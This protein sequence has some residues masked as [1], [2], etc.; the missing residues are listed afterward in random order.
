MAAISFPRDRSIRYGP[1]PASWGA[2]A[3]GAAL[4]LSGALL[5]YFAFPAQPRSVKGAAIFVLA[6]GALVLESALRRRGALRLT[7]SPD[8][9]EVLVERRRFGLIPVST[10]VG[11]GTAS[12]VEVE[13][14][15][16]WP[17]FTRNPRLPPRIG[18]R[19]VVIRS[20]GTR[21]AI[22]RGPRPGGEVHVEAAEA[23]REVLGCDAASAVTAPGRPPVP[24]TL[25]PPLPTPVRAVIGVAVGTVGGAAAATLVEVARGAHLNA[26]ASPLIAAGMAVGAVCGLAFGLRGR[27]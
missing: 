12:R 5:S 27:R 22:D 25:A 19:L 26:P 23:L 15:P 3:L 18:G 20:D 21:V 9:S 6:M 8:R 14:R 11:V 7:V 1:F 13:W 4:I 16:I 17:D 2:A 10:R 24:R